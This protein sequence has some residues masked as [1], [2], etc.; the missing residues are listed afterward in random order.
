MARPIEAT[1]PLE[2][3]DA[4]RLEEELKNVC[5]PEEMAIRRANAKAHLAE[6]MRLKDPEKWVGKA[7]IHLPSGTIGKVKRYELAD[8]VGPRHQAPDVLELEDGNKFIAS[9]L[10]VFEFLSEGEQQLAD[11]GV[12]GVQQLV[13]MLDTIA[14]RLNL[15]SAKAF[16]IVSAVFQMSIRRLDRRPMTP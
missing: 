16:R 11:I 2:G 5:S 8:R 10:S 3:E 1:P 12:T 13:G 7:V 6:V 15:P 14:Q 9:D 4:D